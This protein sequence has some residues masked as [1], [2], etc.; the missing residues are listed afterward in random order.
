MK[1][2][3]ERKQKKKLDILN[4]FVLAIGCLIFF[5]FLR[6]VFSMMQGEV[7]YQ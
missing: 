1:S 7:Y 6:T 5:K 3:T 2:R 4:L